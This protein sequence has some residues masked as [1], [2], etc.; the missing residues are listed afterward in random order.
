MFITMMGYTKL[1]QI[2]NKKITIRGY[3]YQSLVY[4]M[5]DFFFQRFYEQK[6]S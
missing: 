4:H 5:S 1:T 6:S 3:V 2:I